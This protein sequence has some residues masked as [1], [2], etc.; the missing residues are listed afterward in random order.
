MILWTYVML[1]RGVWSIVLPQ[2]DEIFVVRLKQGAIQGFK[3]EAVNGRSFYAFKGIPYAQ[4]PVDDLRFRDPV[5]A[6]AWEGTRD[7]KVQPPVCPQ[8]DTDSFLEGQVKVKGEEDCL[9]LNVFTPQYVDNSLPVMVWIHSGAFTV[10][11]A[12]EYSPS[13]LLTRD[14]VLVT[15]QYRL[16]TLGFLS[17]ED[18]VLPGNLGLKDQTLALRWV[19]DNIQ[20]LGGDPNQ[21]TIFGQSAGAASAHLQVLS[22][23]SRGLFR[24]AILQ[25]GSSLSPW[26]LRSDHKQV[27]TAIGLAF[28]CSDAEETLGAL[29]SKE[30]LLCLQKQ[31]LDDLVAIPSAFV[32]W[33]NNPSVMT[34]RVDWDFLPDYPEVLLKSRRY[35]RV[36]IISGVTKDE[37]ALAATPVLMFPEVKE[38]LTQDLNTIGSVAM[39]FDDEDPSLKLAERAFEHYHC[40]HISVNASKPLV[41]LFGDRGFNVPHHETTRLHSQSIAL[42]NLVFAY[43]LQ[44]R[45]QYS[46]TDAYNT[47]I[48]DQWV[49]HGDDLQYLFEGAASL[50]TLDTPEDLQLRE[51]MVSLWTN[52]A[53]MGNPTPNNSL[54]VLWQPVTPTNIS[55]LALITTPAMIPLNAE[56]LEFWKSLPTKENQMLYPERFR[57]PWK[58]I[59]GPWHPSPLQRPNYFHQPAN[60]FTWYFRHFPNLLRLSYRP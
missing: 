21:V 6:G 13:V 46:L 28:N 25:S 32:V 12:D 3:E 48:T 22:P 58:P 20:D 37:G 53:S 14:V 1:V 33:L 50:P 23:H 43:V 29:V 5:A 35:N 59:P 15:I 30:L 45:G 49:S 11:G 56:V 41:K 2:E 7:G 9:F 52:F 18:S 16:G 31:P 51:L 10:G 42:G 54:G 27:A 38:P 17:T 4:P 19:Q 47:T 8:L 60:F 24:R 26:A 57:K 55:T 39:N 34:P 36:D 40:G 44:H